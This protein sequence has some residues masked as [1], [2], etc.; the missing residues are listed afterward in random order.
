[1]DDEMFTMAIGIEQKARS[2]ENTKEREREAEDSQDP[3]LPVS[4]LV[5]YSPQFMS[6]TNVSGR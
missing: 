3:R 5:V 2:R 6:G 1:M 4:S